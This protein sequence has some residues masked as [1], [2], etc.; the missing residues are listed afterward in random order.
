MI[1]VKMK[2]NII[3]VFLLIYSR[4]PS[5]SCLFFSLGSG[6]TFGLICGFYERMVYLPEVQ[7][8]YESVCENN[9]Q[10][11][12]DNCVNKMNKICKMVHQKKIDG[13]FCKENHPDVYCRTSLKPDNC[14]SCMEIPKIKTTLVPRT[15][16]KV[17]LT[18]HIQYSLQCI[19]IYNTKYMIQY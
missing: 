10:T 9:C 19:S 18:S 8:Y 2:D 4:A 1:H 14:I 12:I 15:V 5:I 13:S 11:I 3:L 17:R 16:M 6:E 7:T